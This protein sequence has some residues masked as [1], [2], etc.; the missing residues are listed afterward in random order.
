MRLKKEII[1][2]RFLDGKIGH[3][4]QSL[5]LVN[6]LKLK[7]KLFNISITNLLITIFINLKKLN[8]LPKPD[9]I[10]GVGHKVHLSV[11]IAK[12][13]F[14]GKSILIMKPSLPAH[15]FNLCIIPEHDRYDGRGLV[16]RTKGALCD[17]KNIGKKN[18]KKGL[19]LIGGLSKNFM[20]NG[21]SVVKQIK[22]LVLNNPQIKFELTTSRRTPMDFFLQLGELQEELENLTFDYKK[23]LKV[24]I[25]KEQ[26]NNW[27]MVKMNEAKFA[28]ITEDSI[29]MI[30]ESLTSG[31]LVGILKLVKNKGNRRREGLDILKKEGWIFYDQDGSF[32]NKNKLKIFPNEAEKSA[33]W[34]KQH[35]FASDQ[36]KNTKKW[37]KT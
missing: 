11:L 8:K 31:Q 25:T 4:K 12:F 26:K 9:L 6:S 29:S 27:I 21:D 15:W 20:W 30:S 34:I 16:Y 2:W 19:I 7:I 35:F 5:A 17:I 10:I 23:K 28:W 32:K 22:Q 33:T 13:L 36:L 14:G 1:I 18:P 37:I 24:S 3:E